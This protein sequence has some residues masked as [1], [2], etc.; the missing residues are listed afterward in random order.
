MFEFC[1]KEIKELI[2]NSLKEYY[3]N[4]M[5]KF[6]V[7]CKQTNINENVNWN[8]I[9][10]LKLN[11]INSSDLYAIIKFIYENEH[12][13][14]LSNLLMRQKNIQNEKGMIKRVINTKNYS[15]IS[16]LINI[17]QEIKKL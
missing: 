5:I 1:I 6:I 8:F 15:F 11:F 4:E 2:N 7:M 12:N 9:Q 16:Y 10:F 17:I 3:K 14:I 13:D